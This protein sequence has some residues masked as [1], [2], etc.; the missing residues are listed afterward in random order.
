M[1]NNKSESDFMAYEEAF[2]SFTKRSLKRIKKEPYIFFPGLMAYLK[3][4]SY[5]I[6]FKLLFKNI[7]IGKHFRVYGKLII[8]GPGRVIF[9]NDCFIIS[10]VTKTVRIT[11]MLPDSKLILGD[12]VGLNGTSIVCTDEINIGDFSNIA[13]AYITDT[14]AHPISIDRRL[15]SVK[16]V[17]TE[18]I[19][20]GRNVWVSVNSVILKGVHIGDNSVIGACSLVRKSLPPNILA[21]GIPAKIIQELP[22]SYSTKNK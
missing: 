18:K 13:D 8:T 1:T 5:K 20:I 16:D 9:G 14:S 15:Y 11:T 21:A 6:K 19:Y 12:H 7:K 3:G 22:I 17:P 10:Q 4:L 2:S